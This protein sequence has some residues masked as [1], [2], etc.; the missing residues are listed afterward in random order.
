MNVHGIPC[1][2]CDH[3]SNVEAFATPLI[4]GRQTFLKKWLDVT[5]AADSVALADWV[6]LR[7]PGTADLLLQMDIEGAEYRNLLGTPDDVLR[8]FRIVVLELHGLEAALAP[9][10][11]RNGSGRCCGSS[12]GTSSACMRIPTTAA[13]RSCCRA[14]A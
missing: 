11:S 8:R 13:G 1:H 10:G 5:G 2:M 7:A 9:I 3:S 14:R 6:A 4:E 12:T